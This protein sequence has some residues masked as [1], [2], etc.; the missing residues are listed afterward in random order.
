M[1][2]FALISAC[3]RHKDFQ[4]N[5]SLSNHNAIYNINICVYKYTQNLLLFINFIKALMVA[6]WYRN[7]YIRQCV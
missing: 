5:V 6:Y 3:V 7:G 2:I 4:R 1:H